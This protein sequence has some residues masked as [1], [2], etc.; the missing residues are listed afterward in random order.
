M[1]QFNYLN[2]INNVAK[3]MDGPLSRGPPQRW[4]KKTVNENINPGLSASFKNHSNVNIS[5][6][7]LSMQKLSVSGNL[8][9]NNSVLSSN[10]TPTRNDNRKGKKTPSKTKSP[11]T[12][13]FFVTSFIHSIFAC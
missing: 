1:A 12:S 5:A 7:N 8:S 4:A 3:T 9:C 10:K 2:E 13:H 11:G 6:C